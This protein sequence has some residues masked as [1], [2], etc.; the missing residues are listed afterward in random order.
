MQVE[1]SLPNPPKSGNHPTPKLIVTHVHPDFDAIGYA[2]LMAKYAPGFSAYQIAYT[3]FSN[4]DRDLLIRADSV[5]D[6]GGIYSPQRWR[7]DHHHLKGTASTATCA[8][9]QTWWHLRHNLSIDL[10]YLAPLIEII[11]QGDLGHT[12]PIGIHAL[13][14]GFAIRTSKNLGQHL[15]DQETM[16]W[17]FELLSLADTWLKRQVEVKTE[18]AQK[19]I[20]KSDDNLVWAIKDG[21]TGTSFAAYS[22]G[23]RLVVFEGKPIKL[24][25]YPQD[26]PNAIKIPPWQKSTHTYP[27]G[28]SRANEWQEPDIIQIVDEILMNIPSGDPTV[29]DEIA[30][31]FVHPAGFFAGRGTSKAPNP[32]PLACSIVKI[33]MSISA[34]WERDNDH[35]K[36]KND[37]FVWVE[38]SST[39]KIELAFY[40]GGKFQDPY[41]AVEYFHDITRWQYLRP[42]IR[43]PSEHNYKK[44]KRDFCSC[45]QID[46][47]QGP[48]H[49]KSCPMFEE[50]SE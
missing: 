8:T 29:C 14:W 3:P 50:V 25:P 26:H 35:F 4:P 34:A 33:A 30:L 36:I 31:W 49:D 9:K 18:L 44:E 27:V 6:I 39:T 1:Y 24:T 13:L 12:D 23:A 16:A 32:K 28:V 43:P 15:S 10:D 11:H 17:G 47:T 38:R 42:P 5:G 41:T 7:F 21:S 22:E 45:N 46:W 19:V 20:W 48:H 2:W 40:S 37:T